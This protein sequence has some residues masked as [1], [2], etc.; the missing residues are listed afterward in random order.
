MIRLSRTGWNNIIIFSVMGF[1]LLINIMQRSEHSTMS[2]INHE[3]TLF[4]QSQIILTLEI[5]QHVT[6]E[7]I[8]RTWRANPPLIKGQALEQMMMSWQQASGTVVPKPRNLDVKMGLIVSLAIMGEP[9]LMQ[10]HLYDY[11]GAL[12]V[13]KPSSEQWYSLPLA[14]YAQLLPSDVL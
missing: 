3:E 12:Y 14:L 11:D 8:G 4:T 9:D 2:D 10:L 7:R 5:S 6:I 1:I 13:Y